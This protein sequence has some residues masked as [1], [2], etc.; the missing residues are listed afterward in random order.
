MNA[1]IPIVFSKLEQ[2]CVASIVCPRLLA[3]STDGARPDGLSWGTNATK[4]P[5]EQLAFVQPKLGRGHRVVFQTRSVVDMA[6]M[7][8][9]LIL[10]YT[11]FFNTYETTTCLLL[12]TDHRIGS[13]YFPELVP[14]AMGMT[15]SPKEWQQGAGNPYMAVR[16]FLYTVEPT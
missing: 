14:W 12:K 7:S 9:I 10:L 5:T 11:Y 1:I 2:Y 6:C 16:N 8:H 15:E 13:D 3:L 4:T